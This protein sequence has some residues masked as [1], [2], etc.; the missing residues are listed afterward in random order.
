MALV[1]CPECKQ[2]VSSQAAACPHCGFP[3][4]QSLAPDLGAILCD[5]PWL[6]QSGTLVDAQLQAAFFPNRTFQGQTTPDPNRVVGIQLVAS[7]SFTG[8]WQVAGS[9]LVFEFPLTMA[10]GPAQTQIGIQFT[11]ISQDSLAGVDLF[12]RPWEWQ[13]L[14]QSS[15]RKGRK[16]R[17]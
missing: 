7:A 9:Q 2:Q 8:T 1:T 15:Q 5:G 17:S 11:H 3:L 13:K 16:T 4:A 14:G 12:G 6:A 10:S